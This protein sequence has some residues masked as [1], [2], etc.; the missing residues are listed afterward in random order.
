[1]GGVEQYTDHL[2]RHLQRSGHRVTI[3]TSMMEGC[4][5]EELSEGVQILRVP[6][7]QLMDGRYPIPKLTKIFWQIHRILRQQSFDLVLVNT[8]F[9]LLS[10]YG[11]FFGRMYAKKVI[12]VEHGSAHLNLGSPLLNRIGAI[13]EYALT[14]VGRCFCKEY[15]GV[16]K[17]CLTWLQHFGIRGKGILYNSIDLEKITQIQQKMLPSFRERYQIPEDAV[18]F[19]YTGRLIPEKGIRQMLAAFS[20]VQSV[21]PNVYLLLAGDGPLMEEVQEASNEHL[22]ALGRLSYEEVIGLLTESQVFCLP[23]D[24]EGFSTAILEAIACHCYVIT[25]QRGGA[26]EVFPTDADGTVMED[27]RVEMIRDAMLQALERKPWWEQMTKEVY[28]RVQKNYTWERVA[29]QVA[30][31]A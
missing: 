4:A 25:T 15:Y 19:V 18:V 30:H 2:A 7:I 26:R 3:L 23:S 10:L 9:Y 27:N 31:L 17:A 14:I 28:H 21:V 1:M 29:D 12:T 24:S 11:Q 22:I 20:Q 6:S 13:Y 8:R 5:V 16:S